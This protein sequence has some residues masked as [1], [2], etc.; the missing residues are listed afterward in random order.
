[1]VEQLWASYVNL[2]L[3]GAL[4]PSS[5][6]VS[7]ALE[8]IRT[9]QHVDGGWGIR[10]STPVG[11]G[12][13]LLALAAVPASLKPADYARAGGALRYLEHAQS[14]DGSWPAAPFWVRLDVI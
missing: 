7:R 10:G 13:A 9:G 14:Q 12:I 4:Q 2:R 3:L 6:V 5:P 8:P 1:Y 11:T